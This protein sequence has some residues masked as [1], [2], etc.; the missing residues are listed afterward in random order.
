MVA[1]AERHPSGADVRRRRCEIDVRHDALM[2]QQQISLLL[3]R[4]I[5]CAPANALHTA[6]A[7]SSIA[8][9]IRARRTA[10]RRRPSK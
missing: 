10:I 7:R 6:A 2:Q 5:A 9:A 4:G 1:E 3:A 8:E